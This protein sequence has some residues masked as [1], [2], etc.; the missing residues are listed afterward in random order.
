MD[1]AMHEMSLIELH[2]VMAEAMNRNA[3]Q[4]IINMIAKELAYR[5]YVPFGEKTFEE[6]LVEKGY[7]VIEKGKNDINCKV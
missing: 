3:D 5:D 2:I 6:I 7:R 1:K 4:S